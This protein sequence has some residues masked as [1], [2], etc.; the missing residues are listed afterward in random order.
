MRFFHYLIRRIPT[1]EVYVSV[2]GGEEKHNLCFY[3]EI[4]I[5]MFTVKIGE[6]KMQILALSKNHRKVFFAASY[7]F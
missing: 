4:S 1:N 5:L 2:G 3:W 6:M 7:Y